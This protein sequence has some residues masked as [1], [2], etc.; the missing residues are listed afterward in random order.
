MNINVY[1]PDDLGKQAKDAELPLS[2]LLREAVK[3]ELERKAMI[4]KALAEPQTFE[5]RLEDGD[6]RAFTGRITGTLIATGHDEVELY[7]TDS[8]R[9][10]GYDPNRLKYWELGQEHTVPFEEELRDFLGDDSAYI[11][12][13]HALGEKPVIDL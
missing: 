13:I 5:L 2:R 10:I 3:D 6:G 12:A 9:V 7:L 11:D 4:T 1:L 8:K